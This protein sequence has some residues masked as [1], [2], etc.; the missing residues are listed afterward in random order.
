[1]R[2]PSFEALG[3]RFIVDASLPNDSINLRQNKQKQAVCEIYYYRSPFQQ[4]SLVSVPNLKL[5]TE[6]GQPFDAFGS[7][8]IG[9]RDY[10]SISLEITADVWPSRCRLCN[11]SKKRSTLSPHPEQT[12]QYSVSVCFKFNS[13]GAAAEHQANNF[14][15][16]S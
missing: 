13:S 14:I 8:L 2:C 16:E 12:N 7:S 5:K 10:P 9:E 3:E 6:R 1:M 11:I 15:T 4:A